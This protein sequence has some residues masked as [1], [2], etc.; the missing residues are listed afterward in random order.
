MQSGRQSGNLVRAG[1]RT[2]LGTVYSQWGGLIPRAG[3]SILKTSDDWE[4]DVKSPWRSVLPG[5]IFMG[6]SGEVSSKLYITSQ[7]IVLV[8]KIDVFREVKGELTPLGLPKAA[9]K[10]QRLKSLQAAGVRQFCE[11][12]PRELRVVRLRRFGTPNR[13]MDIFLVGSDGRKYLVSIW[14]PK[15]A[16]PETLTLVESRFHQEP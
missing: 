8:R 3:E 13:A 4:M 14:K 7:R 11:I 5:V 9:E 1:D 16:D 12:W 15:G 10:E 6:F 2:G